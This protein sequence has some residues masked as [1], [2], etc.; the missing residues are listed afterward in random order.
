MDLGAMVC[1]ASNPKCATCPLEKLCEAEEPATLP[2]KQPRALITKKKEQRLF[3]Q[4]GNNVY[5]EQS[6]GPLW[7]GLW[8]LPSALLPQPHKNYITSVTYPITRYR[9]TMELYKASESPSKKLRSFSQKE[10]EEIAIPSPH[11]RA[12]EKLLKYHAT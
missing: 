8:I 7:K 4:Q 2:R 1:T 11:R 6:A 3:Y 12:I 9:V 5:L 10:I